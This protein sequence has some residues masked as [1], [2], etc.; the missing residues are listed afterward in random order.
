MGIFLPQPLS[1]YTYV[2]V[3]LLK[4][5]IV[6]QRPKEALNLIKFQQLSLSSN[7]LKN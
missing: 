3:L 7:A 2:R 6:V 1:H 5:F 4:H